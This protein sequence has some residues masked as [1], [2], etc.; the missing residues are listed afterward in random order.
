MGIASQIGSSNVVQSTMRGSSIQRISFLIYCD[1]AWSCCHKHHEPQ[2]VQIFPYIVYLFSDPAAAT[3]HERT[4]PAAKL[5]LLQV[6][7]RFT[8][9][10]RDLRPDRKLEDNSKLNTTLGNIMLTNNQ[11]FYRKKTCINFELE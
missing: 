5:Q 9:T 7:S 2:G 1:E 4:R 3:P 10:I 6:R 11:C 8:S